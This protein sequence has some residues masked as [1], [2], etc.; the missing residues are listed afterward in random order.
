[1]PP[2]TTGTA[3]FPRDYYFT[4]ELIQKSVRGLGLGLGQWMVLKRTDVVTRLSIPIT[5]AGYA[6]TTLWW[7]FLM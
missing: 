2:P 5:T 6:L 1:M 4:E 3:P 7:Y